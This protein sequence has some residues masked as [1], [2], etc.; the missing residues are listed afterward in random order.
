[1]RQNNSA[2]RE[3]TGGGGKKW[4]LEN[5]LKKKA[6]RKEGTQNGNPST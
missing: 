1:M 3:Y 5:G 2:T 4:E 6:G